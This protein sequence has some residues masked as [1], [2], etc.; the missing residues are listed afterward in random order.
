M[1]NRERGAEGI[2][3]AALEVFAAKGFRAGSLNEIATRAGYT[4]AGLLHY[5][6]G[7]DAMLLALLERRDRLLG[8][9]SPIEGEESLGELIQRVTVRRERAFG[10]RDVILLYHMLTAEAA[11]AD[12]PAGP[13]VAARHARLRGEISAAVKVSVARGELPNDAD[14]EAFAVALLAFREGVETQW[15]VNPSIDP[16]AVE[17]TVRGMLQA[18]GLHLV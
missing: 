18:I 3:D 9:F 2:L 8:V 5:F 15:L 13:W 1:T 4:R 14:P 17:A 7:K 10:D 16:A 6:S 12:H 11:G